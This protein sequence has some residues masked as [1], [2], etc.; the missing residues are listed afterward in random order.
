MQACVLETAPDLMK[1][2][3]DREGVKLHVTLMN[4][5][6]PVALAKKV[7]ETTGV[8]RWREK[9]EEGRA[10]ARKSFDATKIIQVCLV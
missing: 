7:V 3:F 1:K 6:F 9:Q 10:P 8:V 2:E 4:S 5:R